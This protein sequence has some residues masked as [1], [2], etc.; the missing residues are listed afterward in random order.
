ML[1]FLR[2]E[3]ILGEKMSTSQAL[4]AIW[5]MPNV[6][7]KSRESIRNAIFENAVYDTFFNRKELAYQA[8]LRKSVNLDAL[9]IRRYDPFNAFE[10]KNQAQ[11]NRRLLATAA[12][13]AVLSPVTLGTFL[14]S[15]MGESVRHMLA[16]TQ[17]PLAALLHYCI[18]APLR[19]IWAWTVEPLGKLVV[20]SR[21]GLVYHAKQG[22]KLKALGYGVALILSSALSW[23]SLV[24]AFGVGIGVVAV[25]ALGGVKAFQA[26]AS[27]WHNT[28][29]A[30]CKAIMRLFGGVSS[31]LLGAITN[32][33][34][35]VAAAAVVSHPIEATS[36]CRRSKRGDVF[37]RP[38]E[39]LKSTKLSGVKRNTHTNH[40]V[41]E[42]D[43][44]TRRTTKR[45][46][47]VS[48]RSSSVPPF[49]RRYALA[50]VYGSGDR[51]GRTYNFDQSGKVVNNPAAGI[52][53]GSVL[54]ISQA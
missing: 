14:L 38:S 43:P 39:L 21:D 32:T 50:C 12:I 37:R 31:G 41:E 35:F 48:C 6:K 30:I 44:R 4:S 49:K 24:A 19:T 47:K 42:W 53:A 5:S 29:G 1:P 23:V 52:Q 54:E 51:T 33:A 46:K 34:P 11:H 27:F 22:N 7:G 8:S 3:R 20:L 15:L 18:F 28:V 16:D 2:L 9:N 25:K 13:T 17:S 10:L 26:M 36:S 40:T 45:K